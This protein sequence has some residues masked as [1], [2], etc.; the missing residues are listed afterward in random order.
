[1]CISMALAGCTGWTG[2]AGWTGTGCAGWT[3]FTDF[4]ASQKMS[5]L[6]HI[7]LARM[8]SHP[9][10]IDSASTLRIRCLDSVCGLQFLYAPVASRSDRAAFTCLFIAHS[11]VAAWL[12]LV[13]LKQSCA[14]IPE[15]FTV[16]RDTLQSRS[17]TESSKMHCHW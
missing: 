2:C 16:H 12:G 14:S 10:P 3:H 5:Q 1:M 13:A 7:L 11:I 6:S 4:R 9:M 17:L 8:P 15:T